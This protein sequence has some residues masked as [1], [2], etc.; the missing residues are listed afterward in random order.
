MALPRGTR[1]GTYEIVGLLGI[2][3]M[4]EVYRAHDTR[5][6]R[7]VAIKILAHRVSEDPVLLARIER[8]ARLLASLNHPSIAT[9]HGIEDWQGTPAIVMELIEGQTLA[10]RLFEGAIPPAEVVRIAKQVAEA[11]CAAHDRGIVH[12]DLKPANIHLRPDGAVK[13]LDFGLAKA[14]VVDDNPSTQNLQSVTTTGSI[15]G[16]AP[17]MSP[18]QARGMEMDRRT[19]IWAFGCTVYEMLTG[20]R[21][22]Y[23]PTPADTV[24]AILSSTPDWSKLPADT[25]PGLRA[26]LE[27]CLQRD[28]RQRL[29]DLG[30]ASFDYGATNSAFVGAVATARR[31]NLGRALLFAIPIV[32]ALLLAGTVL[33]FARGREAGPL[34][35]FEVQVDGL[36]DQPGTFT[37]ESGPGA[38][39]VISPDGRR[40]VYP[41]SGRLWVRDLSELASRALDG[42]EKAAAPSWSP[43]SSWVAYAVGAELRKS[44]ISGGAAVRVAAVPG[45]FAEAGGIA[46]SDDGVLYY[47][48]GNGG[49]WKV[50]AEG[51]D[52]AMVIDIEPGV[53][54]Y[55]DATMAGGRPMII[56]H[57]TNSQFS[58]DRVD[59]TSRE[60][61]FGPV[62][63]VI[64]H[65]AFSSD[66]HLVYQRVG[67]S[68]GV[69]GVPVE[70]RTLLQRGEPFLVAAGGL[71]PSV[72]D[73]GTLVYVTDETWGRVQLSFV[74]RT[75]QIRSNVGDPR[76]GMRH[77]ALSPAGDRVVMVA[78]SGVGDDLFVVDVSRGSATQ[79]TSTGVR[80]DPAW[81]PKGRRIAYSCGAT[82]RDGGVCVV[83]ADGGGE[84]AV[85]IPGASQPDYAPDGL[86]LA[87]LLLDPNTRTDL[88]TAPAD[89]SSPATLIRQ[90][91]AFDFGPRVSPDGHFVA[92][93]SAES[94]KPEVYVADYPVPRRR[95][96]V[97][98]GAG[99]EVR[100]N[101]RGG[102]LF[103]LDGTGN[104]QAVTIDPSGQPGKPVTLFSESV[105]RGHLSQGYAPSPDGGQFLLVRDVDR[106]KLRPRITVVQNWFA[107]FAPKR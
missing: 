18:E 100:W 16:T 28:I 92:Y 20:T 83:S 10:V 36:G 50:P 87:Y 51:G 104:L 17:Y 44:P 98:T 41:A 40:I 6:G 57:Y 73:D 84:P 74:D 77:P 38:G 72:A 52:P 75:G 12:R 80:G 42:T 62:A 64:R 96:Q 95:W 31:R 4:G 94:G 8:E 79:L 68:P 91:P 7:D 46:W 59:G 9:I 89:G 1:I 21:A 22:F 45:G 70:P 55:H 90:T 34:R 88:W 101:P 105:A 56:T 85:V 58:I 33:Y 26:L 86:H 106:G 53:R 27:R 37:A 71:R 61:L 25:P 69:W 47:T 15:M 35:K 54:D 93:S 23:G 49:M 3:G 103:Y 24:V 63:Q 65:A 81:D 39:V 11:L 14:I 78:P 43:D 107:E 13:V 60:V 99:A 32:T 2:G 82:G 19:D 5:L 30:D 48:T 67:N 102:E 76:A 66:G 97:S 29:R